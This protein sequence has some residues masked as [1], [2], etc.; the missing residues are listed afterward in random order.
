MSENAPALAQ[1][2]AGEDVNAL[3]Q[4]PAVVLAPLDDLLM[5]DH[6]DSS[7]RRL[8]FS[9]NDTNKNPTISGFAPDPSCIRVGAQFFCVTSSFSAFPGIPV[10]TSRDLV[11]WKQIGVLFIVLVVVWED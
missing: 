10:Y 4:Q 7:N 5:H 3:Y 2:A 11:Q 8:A 6:L 1:L 9:G